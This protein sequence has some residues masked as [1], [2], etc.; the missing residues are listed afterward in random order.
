MRKLK[1]TTKPI[2]YVIVAYIVFLMLATSLV[3]VVPQSTQ[4]EYAWLTGWDNRKSIDIAGS[5]EALTDYQVRVEIGHNQTFSFLSDGMENYASH[6][7]QGIAVNDDYIWTS[8]NDGLW[9]SYRSN[10]TDIIHHETGDHQTVDHNGDIAYVDDLYDGSP[11]SPLIYMASNNNLLAPNP[12]TDIYYYDAETLAWGGKINI[13]GIDYVPWLASGVAWDGAYLWLLSGAVNMTLWAWKLTPQS[14][15]YWTLSG[16]YSLSYEI[17]AYSGLELGYQGMAWY[18]DYAF[19]TIHASSYKQYT[20]IYH[21]T[22]TAFE[23]VQRQGRVYFN[24]TENT[25]GTCDQGLDIYT[26]SSGRTWVYWASRGISDANNDIVRTVLSPGVVCAPNPFTLDLKADY[27]DVRFTASDGNTTLN[28]WRERFDDDAAIFWVKVPYIPVN[29]TYIYVYWGNATAATTSNIFTTFIYGD[30]FNDDDFTNWDDYQATTTITRAVVG[31][32]SFAKVDRNTATGSNGWQI[33]NNVTSMPENYIIEVQHLDNKADSSQGGGLA[34]AF[35][36]A[37]NSCVSYNFESDSPYT[38]LNKQNI[39][40]LW[41]A[42][43]YQFISTMDTLTITKPD[44]RTQSIT[45]LNTSLYA[46][47]FTDIGDYSAHGGI[48]GNEASWDLQGDIGF[49]V[50]RWYVYFDDLRVREYSEHP[51][52]VIN[53]LV[54]GSWENTQVFANVIDSGNFHWGTSQT[55]IGDID[56]ARSGDMILNL[57]GAIWLVIFFLPALILGHRFPRFGFVAGMGLISIL[58]AFSNG[59]FFPVVIATLIG[60]FA[61]LI[62]G[63]SD[64]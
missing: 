45:V 5:Y 20:D 23:E 60:G 56:S 62:R 7:S 27:R 51:P 9:K 6:A 22:G 43:S 40:R 35:N 39:N 33:A 61:I 50:W 53:T 3:L 55:F 38:K 2:Q 25:E 24:N 58:F 30:N 10:G 63:G 36:T 29:G 19:L 34:I 1:K 47:S 44:R 42:S 37:N 8:Y 12:R 57:T 32:Q 49:R 46:Q 28:C 26:D 15:S 59:S 4:A 18:G 64:D 31:G 11:Y 41:G 16:N 17:T 52:T 21:W 13:G 48:K 14:N 54:G